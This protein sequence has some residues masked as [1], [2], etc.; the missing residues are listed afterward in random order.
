LSAQD[1]E[2]QREAANRLRLPFP[3]L[4]D[5]DFKLAQALQLPTFEAAGMRLLERLTLVIEDGR[6]EHVFYP[7]FPPDRNASD[8][9][10]WLESRR[11]T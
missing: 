1:R 6:I 11:P 5:H 8:V 10:G 3:L 4:S 2:Y 7:V 9:T